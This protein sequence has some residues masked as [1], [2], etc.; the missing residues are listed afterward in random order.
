MMVKNALPK[1]TLQRLTPQRRLRVLVDFA[2]G[3]APAA[4]IIPI[5]AAGQGMGSSMVLTRL[6]HMTDEEI[7]PLRE[8]LRAFLASIVDRTASELVK[9]PLD[10]KLVPFIRARGKRTAWYVDGEPRDFLLYQVATVLETV[11]IERLGRCEATDC[12]R[13]CVKQPNKAFCSTRC[14]ARTYMRQLRAE[15]QAER[16][17][18]QYGKKYATRTRRRIH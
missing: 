7:R 6:T 17:R 14:Q 4:A 12:A 18:R 1:T 9:R 11:P 2:E 8:T 3:R 10:L 5:V 16:E 15:E 13:L